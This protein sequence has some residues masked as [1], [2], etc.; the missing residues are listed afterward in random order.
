MKTIRLIGIIL[1]VYALCYPIV[2]RELVSYHYFVQTEFLFTFIGV[3][4]GFALT[5]YTYVTS[6]FENI[7]TIIRQKYATNIPVRDSKLDMLPILHGEIKD[8]IVFLIYALIAV[9]VLAISHKFLIKIELCSFYF[10]MLDIKNA[11]L[12]DIFIL[13]VYALYDLV[14]ASFKI[15][16][17]IVEN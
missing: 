15:S 16:K 17:F 7:K 9:V 13:S 6:M 14:C 12:L 5:L 3:F 1:V 11:F 4:I 8:D 2:L 10:N